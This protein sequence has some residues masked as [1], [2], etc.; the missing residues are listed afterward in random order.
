MIVF[1]FP[2]QGSQKPGM[3]APWVGHP[4]WEL[5]GEAS[6]AVG[7]DIEHLLLEAPADELTE[8]RNA[9]AAT[10]VLSLVVLDAIE[11]LGVEPAAVAGHSLGEYTA[12]VAAGALAFEE[13][14]TL[15]A[16]RGEAMQAAGRER[17]GGMAAVLGLDDDAV[18]VACARVDGDVWVAN[19]NA[20]GQVV[21]AGSPEAIDDLAALAKEAGAKKVLPV[22]VSGAFH[23]PFM[24]PAR[25]R[26]RKALAATDVRDPEL[27][28]YANVDAA[29]H[30][31]AREWLGLLGA[32]LCS[33]VRWRQTLHR[34]H[35]DGFG[36]YVEV[37]PGT[38]LTGLAKRTVSGA[39]VL[40]V[41]TPAD[42]DRLL[43]ALAAPPAGAVGAHEGEHL[44]ATERLVV[45][46][47]AGL[48][49]PAGG[50]DP[51]LRLE[52]GDVLGTVGDHEVRSPFSGVVMGVLAVDG[53]RV[54]ASQPIAWLR[55]S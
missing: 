34:L 6:A 55:T 33:P 2:G 25:E 13:G 15:V 47:A 20:P 40:S 37:G 35:D 27:P 18:E 10:F 49:S 50:L 48:F 26:L 30:T 32:Q 51:G 23:T 17:A 19:Y 14:A 43:E 45:S 16:E 22:P 12:L 24:A 54:T 28:T 29:P 31:D 52:P 42:L 9:Q 3:G 38:V 21:V 1:T 11:R 44:F 5:V 7:R 36:T 41:S 39:R 4:S 8:T 46:P 53:E